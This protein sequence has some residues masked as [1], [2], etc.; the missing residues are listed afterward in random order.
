MIKNQSI[1]TI[2]WPHLFAQLASRPSAGPADHH[3]GAS[4]QP[5]PLDGVRRTTARRPSPLDRQQRPPQ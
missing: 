2:I 4:G 3:A 1:I 5:S